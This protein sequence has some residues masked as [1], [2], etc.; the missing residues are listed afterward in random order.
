MAKL[1][2]QGH[3]SYRLCSDEGTVVY[4]DPYAGDG[5]EL[6]ADVILVTHDHYDH[7]VIDLPGRKPGCAVITWREALEGGVHRS[8]AVGGVQ[9]QAVPA[10]NRNHD[11]NVCVGFLITVDGVKLYAAGDTSKTEAMAGMAALELDYALL[12][13]DGVYNMDPAEA[14]ECSRL[15][16]AKHTIPIHMKPGELFDEEMARA[17]RGKDPLIVRPGQ[18]IAL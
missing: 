15:I 10:S 18:E 16:G 17:F 5:Y 11:P 6:P 1:Y 9:M 3:G 14:A 4:V 2:Y 8:F 7:N 12:P 13:I